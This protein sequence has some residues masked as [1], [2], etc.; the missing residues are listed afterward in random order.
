MFLQMLSNVRQ[1]KATVTYLLGLVFCMLFDQ[2]EGE[3]MI[4]V[5]VEQT[6][7]LTIF[8]MATL[9]IYATACTIMESLVFCPLFNHYVCFCHAK[10]STYDHA[11]RH[12]YKNL[13]QVHTLFS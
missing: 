6:T 10:I 2:L 9:S 13:I 8:L 7:C 4:I 11:V 12:P 5:R 1:G 3:V